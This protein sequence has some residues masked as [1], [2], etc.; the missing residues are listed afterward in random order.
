LIALGELL[1]ATAY[2][3]LTLENANRF[4]GIEDDVLEEIFAFMIRDSRLMP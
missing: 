1:A 3:H 2:A 4:Y